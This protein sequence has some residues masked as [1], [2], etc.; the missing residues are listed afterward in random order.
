GHGYHEAAEHAT[1]GLELLKAQPE[2]QERTQ[3]EL[4]LQVMLGSALT[5]FKGHAAREVEQAY[6]R[7]RELYDRVDET[8]RLFPVMRALGWFYLVRG[9]SDSA[10]EMGERLA[11]MAEASGD[12]AMLLATHNALGLVSFYRGEFGDALDHLD[13]GIALYD[14]TAHNQT[15]SPAFRPHQDP[16]VS[17]TTHAGL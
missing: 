11:T 2:S 14:P 8:P 7:A 12:A 5:A 9:P 3:Q 1:R 15:R 10:R 6:A 13:R 16:G 17:C 4:M